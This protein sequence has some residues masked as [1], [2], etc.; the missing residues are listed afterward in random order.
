MYG[1]GAKLI[2]RGDYRPYIFNRPHFLDLT[3]LAMVGDGPYLTSFKTTGSYPSVIPGMQVLQGGSGV[4]PARWLDS[5]QI[6]DS[7]A[8]SKSGVLFGY[9]TKQDSHIAF[10][11]SPFDRLD[12]SWGANPQITVETVLNTSG[13]KYT[14]AYIFGQGKYGPLQLKTNDKNQYIV[15]IACKG[16]TKTRQY[17]LAIPSGSPL[18]HKLRFSVDLNAGKVLGYL[19]K[20]PMQVAPIGFAATSGLAGTKFRDNQIYPFQ[21][22]FFGVVSVGARPDFASDN[23]RIHGLKFS[24]GVLYPSGVPSTVTDKS[25]ITNDV[26]CFA[27]MVPQVTTYCGN[28]LV[29]YKIGKAAGDTGSDHGYG[30]VI[31]NMTMDP[32]SDITL[33][34]ICFQNVGKFGQGVM[35]GVAW[36][37][38]AN[39]CLTVGGYKGWGQIRTGTSSFTTNLFMC[40]SQ[41]NY[42]T[43]IFAGNSIMFLWGFNFKS[44]GNC[45]M[46][47]IGGHTESIGGFC[48]GALNARTDYMFYLHNSIEQYQ[49]YLKGLV[50]DGETINLNKG[51]VYAENANQGKA[52]INVE[53]CTFGTMAAGGDIITLIGFGPESNPLQIPPESRVYFSK[54]KFNCDTFRSVVNTDSTLWTPIIDMSSC[55]FKN[56]GG[57]IVPVVS[58]VSGVVPPGVIR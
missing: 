23:I 32:T 38:T 10:M 20:V 47:M 48:V 17:T 24:K 41:Y 31:H 18:I 35:N 52:T 46:R 29:Q 57:S 13:I 56:N 27:C 15:E 44:I 21:I 26:N 8:V 51:F 3:G 39:K 34:S 33:D 49:F 54:N 1:V 25:I 6:L 12:G 58:L 7:T 9:E 16:E 53:G 19:D 36:N 40:A 42:D 28:R 55:L 2:W 4:L 14:N 45:A 22:G 5:Y 50:Y 43:C 11:D 30:Y 37:L